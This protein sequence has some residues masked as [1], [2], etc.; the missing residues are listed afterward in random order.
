MPIGEQI[1]LDAIAPPII[2]GI[3]WMMSRGWAATVQ[4]GT[5]T[6]RTRSRQK[7]RFWVLL[8]ILYVLMFG[9]TIYVNLAH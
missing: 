4:M 8:V 1:L 6:D 7:G 5:V 9:T 2:A 3:W